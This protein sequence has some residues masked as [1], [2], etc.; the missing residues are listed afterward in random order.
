M[1]FGKT[2]VHHQ[3]KIGLKF[4]FF[5]NPF[6]A[7]TVD[8]KELGQVSFFLLMTNL[9]GLSFVYAFPFFVQ[10]PTDLPNS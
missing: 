2:N 9:S 5:I 6:A 1:I 10:S 7:T 3:N 4:R 8:S